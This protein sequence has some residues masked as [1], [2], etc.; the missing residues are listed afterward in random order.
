[1]QQLRADNLQKS[2][3]GRPVVKG[4]SFEVN[5]GEIVGL[6]GPNGAGKTTSFY[7]TVGLV[8][9]TGGDV[10]L[11]DKKNYSI[12]RCTNVHKMV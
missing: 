12:P 6:L 3:K 2:Y 7:M 4:V 9:P 8:K 1:M 10:W 11:D 5:Q